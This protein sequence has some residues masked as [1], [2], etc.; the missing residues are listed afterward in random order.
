MILCI[1]LVLLSSIRTSGP[2]LRLRCGVKDGIHI[3]EDLKGNILRM[4]WCSRVLTYML[5]H[6]YSEAQY[7]TV[8][9]RLK[10]KMGTVE[11]QLS[12]YVDQPST[13]QLRY[14]VI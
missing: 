6:F 2:D 1:S 10:M 8:T 7:L 3:R 11:C 4:G 12:E 13:N 5:L 9:E 14:N